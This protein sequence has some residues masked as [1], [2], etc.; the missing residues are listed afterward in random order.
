MT[1]GEKFS[2]QITDFERYGTY[3]YKYDSVGNVIFNSASNYFSEVYLALPLFNFVYNNSKINEFY[4]PNFVEFIPTDTELTSSVDVSQIKFEL[5][6][7]KYKNEELTQR[8]SSLISISETNTSDVDIKAAKQVILELRKSL[9][10]GR[11]DS[12]FS[13]DFPYTPVKK[14]VGVTENSGEIS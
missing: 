2:K 1:F 13:E 7:E 14:T 3:V 6:S 12:D 11:V 5:E 9:G 8:L 10:Q 4:D